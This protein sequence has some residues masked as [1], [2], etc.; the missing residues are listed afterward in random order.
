MSSQEVL[1]KIDYTVQ[2]IEIATIFSDPEFNCRQEKIV[3]FDVEEL[4]RDIERNGLTQPIV[5]QP[6]SD[7]KGFKYRVVVGHR[8]L[9]AFKNLRRPTIPAIIRPDL[10]EIQARTLNLSENIQRKD[11]NVYQEAK[12]MEYFLLRG[13]SR[14]EIAAKLEVSVG[15]VQIRATVLA[16]P[17][18]IQREVA[19]GYI[20]QTQIKDIYALHDRDK[21]FEAVRHIKDQKLKNEKKA[22]VIKKPAK[23]TDPTKRKVQ[24]PDSLTQMQEYLM[25]TLGAS[26]ATRALAWASGF[27]STQDL[28]DDVH[29]ECLMKGAKYTKPD[30]VE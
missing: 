16:L 7:I 11:L 23:K 17:Y 8:R 5:I 22:I 14:E 2:D 3:P 6:W 1:T 21:M 29:H 20:T 26:L 4:A 27:I 18:E 24:T 19:A 28:L 13:W 12:A 10:D 30:W 9:Q 15:W 25:D